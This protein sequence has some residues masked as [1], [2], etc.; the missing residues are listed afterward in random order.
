MIDLIIV[1]LLIGLHFFNSEWMQGAGP[2]FAFIWCCARIVGE[3]G[4]WI[5][6]KVLSNAGIERPMKPQEEV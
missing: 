2:G 6:F 3:I 5:F 1:A 4:A